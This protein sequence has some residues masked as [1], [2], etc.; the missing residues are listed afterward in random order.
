MI[1]QI[2]L[3]LFIISLNG[4]FQPAINADM[5]GMDGDIQRSYADT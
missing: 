3:T 1:K 5:T 2:V 4:F